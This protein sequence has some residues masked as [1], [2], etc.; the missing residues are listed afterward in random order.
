MSA[1]VTISQLP[2]AS[3]LTGQ[4]LVP[5][6]Q[7]GVTVQTTTGAISGAGA[8]NYPFLTVGT[9]AG[10]TQARYLSTSAGLS[11]SDTGAGGQLTINMTGPASS[12]NAAGTGI[13]VKNGASTVTSVQ[14]AVGAGMTIA[15]ADGV[16]GNPTLGLSA[17]LQNISSTSAPGL[18]TVN[19]TTVS[20]STITGTTNQ[21]S[22]ANG[23]G[24]SGAPTVGLASDPVVPGTGSI[25]VPSGTTA[26]R[27]GSNGA[28][29]YNTNF[30][31][32]E[33]YTN[34][35]W[36]TIVSSGVGVTSIATG[37]GL[38]GGPI[39]S[40]GT[41][42][43]ANTGVAAG[44]YTFPTIT[45]NAQGQITSASNNTGEIT[46]ISF[47]T[48]GLTPNTPTSGNVVVAGTL[49]ATNGGT[50][51]TS[52]TANGVV[53]A[54][55][56][57][58]LATGTALT[59][60]GTTL[61]VG[62]ESNS[63]NL[64]FTGTGNR[65]TGDFSNA[66]VANRVYFQTSTTNSNT[67]FGTL[68]S[69]TATTAS[70]SVWNN[71]D[72]T[73]AAFFVVQAN[74]STDVRL[75][76]GIAGTGTY[77]PMTFYT[78]GS[79]RAR[80]D[81][82]G[83][84]GIG[85]SSPAAKL[86]VIGDIQLSRSATASDAA[87][88]FGSN[89]NNYIYSGNSSNIMAFATNGSERMRITNTGGVSIATTTDAGAG[90]LLMGTGNI[91]QGTAAKGFN[92]TANTPTAGMTSQLLNWYEEGTFTPV[93][94]CAT[95]GDLSVTY[96]TQLGRYT[97]IGNR[98]LINI[99]LLTSAFTWTTASGGLRVTGLPFTPNNASNN[100]QPLALIFQGIT[101]AG[102]T[103]F[104]AITDYG[105]TELVF[106]ASGTAVGVS[107]VTIANVPSAGTVY[108]TISGQYQI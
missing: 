63:G 54:S 108:L 66:T 85:T 21:I 79:E 106:S 28:I 14:L 59:F 8:L 27:S 100:N 23:N 65:I 51:L 73:N 64:T 84:V 102:Y 3:A 17:I 31:V 12:L 29:R 103:Q 98:C 2:T 22:I 39:T 75:N 18:L 13:V 35:A 43:I 42:S 52:F 49:A 15:N 55:S 58:A 4:E 45:V 87:I 69:G 48:T 82:S 62:G 53:Y 67:N 1:Q 90:N 94:T 83:N 19:G 61:S 60:N 33:A 10:L 46:T 30:A 68:P 25:T 93:I 92:F 5:I 107:A 78:G 34:G 6:V 95:P 16:A 89:S 47:G 81:T 97:R 36:N 37:T 74:G 44:T 11:L 104:A 105:I 57:S 71:S 41:I 76:S 70:L 99:T 9:T 91:T 24:V 40:T 88:N 7:S 50:G 86:N 72:P 96:S 77:L 26:Q 80:I 20:V 101:K 38:T 32:L 56:T